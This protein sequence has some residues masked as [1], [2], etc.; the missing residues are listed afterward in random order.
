MNVKLIKPPSSILS[1]HCGL[2][3]AE[4]HCLAQQ[5]RAIQSPLAADAKAFQHVEYRWSKAIGKHDQHALELVLSPKLI[6][7]HATGSL[8]TRNQRIA[9]LLGK[10][11][12]PLSLDHCVKCRALGGSAVVIGT[13]DE[14]LRVH[15]KPISRK[16]M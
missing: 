11:A 4:P 13:C 8:T 6:D 2:F 5:T 1:V 3:S 15:K 12:E 9:M 10:G 16:G 7:A 14:Q